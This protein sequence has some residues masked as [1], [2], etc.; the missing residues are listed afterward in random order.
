[1]RREHF[2]QVKFHEVFQSTLECCHPRTM[3]ADVAARAPS[4]HRSRVLRVIMN[5]DGRWRVIRGV[6]FVSC[7][8][9][10]SSEPPP[11]PEGIVPG[12]GGMPVGGVGGVGGSQGGAAGGLSLTVGG[13][14][15]QDPNVDADLDGYIGADDCD[16]GDPQSNPGAFDVPDN[17]VDEDCSGTADD[18]PRG[19]DG[20]LPLDSD[21]AGAAKALG[22]C[23][24][25]TAGASGKAKTWGV[26]SARFVFPDGS[27]SST[28]KVLDGLGECSATPSPPHPLSHG[29]LPTFG[30][31][32]APREGGALTALSS[33]IARA[34]VQEL[35]AGTAYSSFSP[36][37]A[38]MCTS[39][40]APEGFPGPASE[41]C[42][43]IEVPDPESGIDVRDINDPIALELVIRAPTNANS[44]AFDF[45]FYTYE[46]HTFVCTMYNDSFV[47]LLYSKSPDVPVDHNISFDSQRNAVSVNNG[48]VE[49]CEPY[50]YRGVRGGMEITREFPCQYGTQQL[51]E[52]GFDVDPF[53]PE[54]PSFHAATG[55]LRTQANIVP[56]EELTLRFAIWDTGDQ[57]LDSTV[58]L[59][60]FTWEAKPGQNETVRPPR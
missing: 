18:E 26:L 24:V 48:F 52:T 36:A 6:F 33:G 7:L 9:A 54:L 14:G 51:L 34:G 50:T 3:S 53:L 19:C 10:C 41:G 35:N 28:G 23:R 4:A 43:D 32:V 47:T 44:F 60:A 49:V 20:A 57:S 40:R 12:V 39:G 15:S 25:A 22:L 42:G 30:P 59:D 58:L 38:R 17:Q 16:D 11:A 55:W 45:N 37:G 21:A 31:N 27:E 29:V 8:A 5:G 1:V 13:T 46:Y 56:G 2:E